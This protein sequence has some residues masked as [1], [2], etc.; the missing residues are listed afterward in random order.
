MHV[1]MEG[2]ARNMEYF[3]IIQALCRAALSQPS[4]AV[5]KQIERLRDALTREGDA[6]S[7]GVLTG[8]LTAADRTTEISPSRIVQARAQ[9][10]GETI[11]SN[12]Q[13]PVDRETSAP[14]A[15]LIFPSQT[16][17]T[18]PIFNETVS[19]AVQAVLEEWS[20]LEPLAEVGVQAAKTCLIY[21]APGTGKTRLALWMAAQ[22]ELP[23]L[24]ARIDGLVS[25]FLG[26]TARN[27]A[28]L[29]AFANRYRCVLLL[30]EF[31]AFAKL[32]DDPQEVGEI[33]RV[34]NA[35]LQN[36]DARHEVGLTIGITN[37]PH[38]LDSA[39][40]RRFEVQLEIAKPVFDVRVELA[41]HFMLPISAPETHLKMI[42]WFTEGATGAEIE[43]LVRTY[44]KAM[45]VQ[46]GE[47][48][49]LLD[50]LRRFATLN[51]G[52]ID[53]ARKELIFANNGVL[54]RS[55]KEDAHLGFSLE[56][57][58]HIAGKDKSTVGRQIKSIKK[59]ANDT[60]DIG[61]HG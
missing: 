14:L 9:P 58:G 46:N 56:D 49:L 31:D 29:F 16:R 11:T 3:P 55:M 33:K 39:V 38:L 52:R 28:N 47:E 26:T 48:R 15:Q 17:P 45:A 10:A 37:H 25:S 57:I 22:L 50:T 40:W 44:K 32:R 30:D 60:E 61:S 54:F 7:A 27:I 41:R 53:P 21:G 23:I 20:N 42:A 13:V 59:N 34:V 18:A 2:D 43:T 12:T 5:R 35:L 8:L 19:N 6:K 51:S 1:C 24:L 4:P 36:L